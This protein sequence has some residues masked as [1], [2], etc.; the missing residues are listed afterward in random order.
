MGLSSASGAGTV[1]TLRLTVTFSAL[2]QHHLVLQGETL[3]ARSTT[4]KYFNLG[5][6]AREAMSAL[7]NTYAAV[8][9]S[10]GYGFNQTF[11]FRLADPG[12]GTARNVVRGQILFQP[13]ASPVQ[14][15]VQSPPSPLNTC[16]VYVDPG[17]RLLLLNDAGTAWVGPAAVES[18]GVLR[19]SQCGV[20]AGGSSLVWNDSSLRV[21]L[22]M[23]FET[24][25]VGFKNVY[26]EVM[27]SVGVSSGYL[28]MGTWNV[29]ASP[30]FTVELRNYPYYTG[31]YY[32]GFWIRVYAQLG[33]ETIKRAQLLITADGT[34][35]NACLVYYDNGTGRH[36]L[37]NDEGTAWITGLRPENN[38]CI[39][40]QP[41]PGI[42]AMTDSYGRVY[43]NV[44][45]VGISM[46][47]KPGFAGQRMVFAEVLDNAGN[48]AGYQFAGTINVVNTQP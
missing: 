33:L 37:L 1:L 41:T 20:D 26:A 39:V 6:W 31:E 16:L 46:Q 23:R 36:L 8:E 44:P 42:P 2:F 10:F 48:T 28:T 9:P 25:F 17:G 4:S 14:R 13:T 11:Q 35:K 47:I 32:S 27:N 22:A 29:G 21:S 45:G 34:A 43:T 38:Q 19:N 15:I 30:A 18:G 5:T 7:G 24:S 3:D 40:E 12:E